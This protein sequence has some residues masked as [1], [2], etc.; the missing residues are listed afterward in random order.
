MTTAG[1][2]GETRSLGGGPERRPGHEE[3]RCPACGAALTD[4]RPSYRIGD[5][6][7]VRCSSCGTGVTVPEPDEAVL[8]RM[9]DEPAYY[10]THGIRHS[11]VLPD[12]RARARVVD[13]W[14]PGPRVLEVGTGEG[15]LLAALRDEGFDVRGCEISAWAAAAA[16]ERFGLDVFHGEL[17][18]AGYGPASFDVVLMYHVLEHVSA[19]RRL[20]SEAWQLLRPGG[21]LIAEV[22]NL[23]SA[24]MR[25]GRRAREHIL[26]L[27]FHL[28]HFT[29]TGLRTLLARQ[30][31]RVLE[32][33][34][35]F[36]PPF[37]PV[38]AVYE[39]LR[40]RRRASGGEP[41]AST[42][43]RERSAGR[44][45]PSVGR[46]EGSPDR[47]G[48]GGIRLPADEGEHVRERSM[49]VTAW[50]ARILERLR[51]VSSAYKMTAYAERL[52]ECPPSGG[53]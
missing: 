10:E 26:D 2:A 47:P 9:Y 53:G 14:A 7:V 46:R 22:P 19:P 5:W 6:A 29:P 44:A 18:A 30:G 3:R 52:E 1:G 4:L 17:A 15:Y 48:C 50:K 28:V 40:R 35:P 12:H 8:R 39:A 51:A 43:D 21:L 49:R 45:G 34:I 13:A 32:L 20:L 11:D 23:D 31:F 38:L 33:T 36:G 25:Y 37:G 24:Q 27:P 41:S 16:R 42:G